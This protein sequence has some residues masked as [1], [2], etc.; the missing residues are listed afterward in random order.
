M[1]DFL[2]QNDVPE[3]HQSLDLKLK[4]VYGASNPEALQRVYSTW[5]KDYDADLARLGYRS[6]RLASAV[7]AFYCS[8]RQTPILDAGAGTGLVG[9][10]LHDMGY[11]NLTAMG[12]SG[13]MLQETNKRGKYLRIEWGDMEAQLPFR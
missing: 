11:R 1:S 3:M 9:T 8:N 4:G 13:E 2:K 12:F 6:P 10:W 7:L 5:A